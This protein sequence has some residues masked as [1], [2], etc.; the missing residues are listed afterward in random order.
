LSL[1]RVEPESLEIR[2]WKKWKIKKIREK[3]TQ[4]KKNSKKFTTV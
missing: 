3:T 4:T 2:I 1:L